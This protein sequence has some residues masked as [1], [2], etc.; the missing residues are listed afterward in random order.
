MKKVKFI[1]SLLM[2]ALPLLIFNCGN[3]LARAAEVKEA[4]KTDVV[5]VTANGKKYHKA[6]CRFI[7]NRQV[8]QVSEKDAIT[9]G[10]LPCGKCFAAEDQAKK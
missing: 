6:D 7:K 5:C 2:L 1:V 8:S 10:L 9:K 4:K 3:S